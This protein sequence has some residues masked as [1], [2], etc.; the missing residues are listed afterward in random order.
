MTPSVT[1]ALPLYNAERIVNRAVHD[2]LDVSQA[3]TDRFSIILVDNGSTDDTYEVAY[4]LSRC[5][6]QITVLWQPVRSGLGT[7]IELIRTRVTT[8]RILVH[9]GVSLICATQ[10]GLMLTRTSKQERMRP[11]RMKLEGNGLQPTTKKTHLSHRFAPVSL[12]SENMQ[13]AHQAVE[14]PAPY[15]SSIFNSQS[16]FQ[17]IP[18]AK[19]RS[20]YSQIPSAHSRC[21]TSK[22]TQET[23]F[24]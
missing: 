18:Q 14:T 10:L 6:P 15:S 9:D 16:G 4:E 23:G 11:I 20:I 22:M 7:V 24:I 21:P 8:D 2:L 1:I 5:Y 17:W 13:L 3:A 19:G 12:L